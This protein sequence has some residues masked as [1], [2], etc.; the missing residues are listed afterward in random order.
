M[1]IPF[2]GLTSPAEPLLSGLSLGISDV[3]DGLSVEMPYPFAG[4]T[5][6]AEPLLSGLSLG[7]SDVI[8][9][10]KVEMPD[11]FAGLAVARDARNIEP[12]EQISQSNV[13]WPNRSIELKQLLTRH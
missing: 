6:P 12:G 3:I 9:G 7:I 10:L 4:L 13:L 1:E 11:P 8:D 2:A 5:S